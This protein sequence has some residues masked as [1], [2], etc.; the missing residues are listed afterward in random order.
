MD[1]QVQLYLLNLVDLGSHA[2]VQS[3]AVGTLIPTFK[4]DLHVLYKSVLEVPTSTGTSSFNY[5]KLLL[6]PVV[7]RQ[8]VLTSTVES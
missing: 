3:T 8:P 1:F 7:L 4:I 6:V 5:L 2:Y